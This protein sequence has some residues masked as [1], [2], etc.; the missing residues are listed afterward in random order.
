MPDSTAN[1]YWSGSVFP[2]ANASS[3]P[4]VIRAY[5]T[6]TATHTASGKEVGIKFYSLTTLNDAGKITTYSDYFDS[7]SLLPKDE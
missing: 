3:S 7:N 5:G 1:G 4:N 6:W 2:K